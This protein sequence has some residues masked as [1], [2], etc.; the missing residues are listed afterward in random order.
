VHLKVRGSDEA[1][2]DLAQRLPSSTSRDYGR[3]FADIFRDY[4]YDFYK[5]DP[6]LFA[7]AEVWVSNLDSGRTWHGGGL[8][9][10]LLRRL[11]L[12]A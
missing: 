6:A 4:E 2:R 5:I 8:N 1:A 10:D 7:P 3:S 9:M 11:W 12:E